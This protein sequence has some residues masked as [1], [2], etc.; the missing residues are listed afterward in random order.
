MTMCAAAAA[1]AVLVLAGCGSD[2]TPP[3]TS[4][5]P[6]IET[7]ATT[8][9]TAPATETS[10]PSPPPKAASKTDAQGDATA[11]LDLVRFSARRSAGDVTITWTLAAAP[12]NTLVSAVTNDYVIAA[13]K[14]Y[15][16][17][18]PPD[19]YVFSD[20]NTY[21]NTYSVQGN[22]VILTVPEAELGS[23]FTTLTAATERVGGG[24][25][26]DGPTITVP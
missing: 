6:P 17:G 13:V 21:L 10:T 12:N 16:G 24:P 18:A 14:V 11:D 5:E 19:A 20:R 25:D 4:T 1:S 7:T 8:E 23:G 2:S 22:R 26:D 15:A 3:A 9:A